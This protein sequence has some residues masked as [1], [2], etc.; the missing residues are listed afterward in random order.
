MI[1]IPLIFSSCEKEEEENNNNNSNF[2]IEHSTWEVGV[3]FVRDNNTGQIYNIDIGGELSSYNYARW[4][5]K[6]NGGGFNE[7]IS[8]GGGFNNQHLTFLYSLNN[9]TLSGDSISLLDSELI[10]TSDIQI[11]EIKNNNNTII[12]EYDEYYDL[13]DYTITV[14][15]DRIQ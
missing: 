12:V 8:E 14:E 5:F 2:N 6:S 15:L 4:S 10:L 13:Y 7:V 1:T 11:L 3:H 9:I